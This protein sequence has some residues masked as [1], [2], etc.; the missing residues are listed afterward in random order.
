MNVS[1]VT[2]EARRPGSDLCSLPPH[3]WHQMSTA[4]GK[5][6]GRMGRLGAIPRWAV[7]G[8]V[9]FGWDLEEGMILTQVEESKLVLGYG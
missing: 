7:A 2:W 5:G 1:W 6:C 4:S 8:E 9:E 3:G